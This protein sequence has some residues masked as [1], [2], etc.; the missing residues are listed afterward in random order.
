MSEVTSLNYARPANWDEPTRI[1]E[2]PA[3]L[4]RIMV[5]IDGSEQA[6][7]SLAH[8]ARLAGWSGAELIVLVAFDPPSR[9]HRRG[10]LP[11]QELVYGMESDAK[12]LAGEATEL[13]IARGLKARGIA[14]RGDPAEAIVAVSEDEKVDLIVMG[15]RGVSKLRGVL[16]GSVSERV[17]RHSDIP[18]MVV[19]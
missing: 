11:P 4:E 14:V 8:A 9:L 16:L 6:E 10:M 1:P 5:A 18:V 19:S 7:K 3:T 15:R 2:L 17:T 12:E 13:L